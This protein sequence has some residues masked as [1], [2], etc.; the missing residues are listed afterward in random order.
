[1]IGRRMAFYKKIF[2]TGIEEAAYL[3]SD[4]WSNLINIVYTDWQWIPRLSVR[5]ES[6]LALPVDPRNFTYEPA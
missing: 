1:M 2:I 5:E 6:L 3:E 4:H